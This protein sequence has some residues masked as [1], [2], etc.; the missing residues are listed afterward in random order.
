MRRLR[1][2][3]VREAIA[4]VVARGFT[5][6]VRNG[7]KHF[8]VSWVANG[9]RRVLVISQSPSNRKARVQSRAVLRRLLSM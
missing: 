8:K 3:L 6:A 9:R 5:P 1:N 4:A 2:E 7:G